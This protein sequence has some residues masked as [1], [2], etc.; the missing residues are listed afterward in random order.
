M[1]FGYEWRWPFMMIDI[2]VR[3]IHAWWL[4]HFWHLLYM[5]TCPS[6]PDHSFASLTHPPYAIL[7]FLTRSFR[8]IPIVIFVFLPRPRLSRFV[9]PHFSVPPC[10][11]P[12]PLL[13]S[14]YLRWCYTHPSTSFTN[15]T[16]VFEPR[17]LIY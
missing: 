7:A 17:P 11:L 15:I 5:S 2:I 13:T 4:H 12:Y 1:S 6:L 9:I 3:C 16:G 10:L 8:W 14:T